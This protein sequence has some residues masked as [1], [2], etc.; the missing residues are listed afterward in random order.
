MGCG[1]SSEQAG[2]TAAQSPAQPKPQQQHPAPSTSYVAPPSPQLN[3]AAPADGNTTLAAAPRAAPANG[4]SEGKGSQQ[5]T[6]AAA[7]TADSESAAAA[8]GKIAVEK[9]ASEKAVADKA[10]VEKAAATEAL[11]AD[12]E[13]QA[14]DAAKQ[15]AEKDA[16]KNAAAE[17]AAAAAKEQA[18]AASK[19]VAVAT[20]LSLLAAAAPV[21]KSEELSNEVVACDESLLF[22]LKLDT[23]ATAEELAVV[24]EA[25]PV[26]HYTSIAAADGPGCLDGRVAALSW[27]WDIAKPA[28][29]EE[30]CKLKPSPKIVEA[31]KRARALGLKWAWIDW[32][33]VPQYSELSLILNHVRSSRFIYEKCTVILVDTVE[34]APGLGLHI[35]TKDYMSR[36]WTTA[37][38][39]SMLVN[40]TVSYGTFVQIRK[41]NWKTIILAATATFSAAMIR[42][43]FVQGYHAFFADNV[44]CAQ[45]CST[46]HFAQDVLHQIVYNTGATPMREKYGPQ[47]C[48]WLVS[49]PNKF[50]LNLPSPLSLAEEEKLIEEF[51]CDCDWDARKSPHCSGIFAAVAKTKRMPNAFNQEEHY[52]GFLLLAADA[53][54]LLLREWQFNGGAYKSVLQRLG[55]RIPGTVKQ[56]GTDAKSG[57]LQVRNAERLAES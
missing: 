11:R 39:A 9:A 22:V 8:A 20:S 23:A 16:R 1:A 24:H 35:P 10:A 27:R 46:F 29:L 25:Q 26:H 3:A 49:N 48:E 36:L 38:M 57:A 41:W 32:A 53:V 44:E 2:A 33:V 42:N 5:P 43:D 50:Q 21:A 37:E 28:T 13:L 56:E 7:A 14:H 15:Q 18:A 55:V 51:A 54:H 40:P 30:A 47:L 45:P 4:A 6:D 12:A 34:V 17:K 52:K 19:P 31:I